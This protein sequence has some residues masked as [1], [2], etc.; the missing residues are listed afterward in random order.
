[1]KDYTII[2]TNQFAYNRINHLQHATGTWFLQHVK[3]GFF[4]VAQF[5]DKRDIAIARKCIKKAGV[6]K[7]VLESRGTTRF[8]VPMDEYNSVCRMI[9]PLKKWDKKK[10][11][12]K[13]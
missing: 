2:M 3:S 5:T 13:C 9:Y 11:K 6:K 1:M 10:K 4:E 12:Q 7:V 8:F